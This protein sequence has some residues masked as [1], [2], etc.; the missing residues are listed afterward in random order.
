M[1]SHPGLLAGEHPDTSLHCDVVHSE[2]DVGQQHLSVYSQIPMV[3]NTPICVAET[4]RELVEGILRPQGDGLCQGSGP[5][6]EW[7]VG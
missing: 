7:C 6:P 3:E 4:V 1:A 2:P 5:S